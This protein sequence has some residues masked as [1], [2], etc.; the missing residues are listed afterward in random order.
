VFGFAG[1]QDSDAILYSS[2]TNTN[3]SLDSSDLAGSQSLY[4]Q[5]PLASGAIAQLIQVA[6]GYE[7]SSSAGTGLI[8]GGLLQP[9]TELYAYA[10]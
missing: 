5:Q 7:V 3:R 4:R 9:Q 8:P 6:A 10:H 2:L 1:N